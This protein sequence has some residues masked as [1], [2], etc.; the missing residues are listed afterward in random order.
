MHLEDV[1]WDEERR[2]GESWSFGGVAQNMDEEL[3]PLG[4]S[5]KCGTVSLPEPSLILSFVLLSSLAYF[6]LWLDFFRLSVYHLI[7]LSLIAHSSF[8][9][10]FY[11]RFLATLR[12]L[13]IRA[14]FYVYSIKRCYRSA[15]QP[16][17]LGGQRLHY[18]ACLVLTAST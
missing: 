3:T 5:Y 2:S 11:L 12:S 17:T 15:S 13:Q 8:F 18:R 14:T 16:I 4:N 7:T 9:E 6:G 1:H 10:P